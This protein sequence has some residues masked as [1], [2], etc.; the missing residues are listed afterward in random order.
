MYLNCIHQPW[1]YLGIVLGVQEIDVEWSVVGLIHVVLLFFVV[2]LNINWCSR[3]DPSISA[4]LVTG[5][6][7]ASVWS[8]A[9]A[10]TW[11]LSFSSQCSGYR[12]AISALGSC[13]GASGF[14]LPRY[15]SSTFWLWCQVVR[16]IGVL[17]KD[18]SRRGAFRDSFRCCQKT[19]LR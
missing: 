1:W 15:V 7:L 8:A 5:L 14:C 9:L 6:A 12:A 4:S 18:L 17:L 10:T 11:L 16:R 2:P 19:L 13:P 3:R